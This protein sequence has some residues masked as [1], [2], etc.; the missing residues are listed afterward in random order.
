MPGLDDPAGML[1]LLLQTYRLVRAVVLLVRQPNGRALALLVVVQLVGGTVFYTLNEGW[2]WLDSLYSCV[3]TL[4]TVGLGDLAPATAAGR[5]FTI[6]FIF[7]GVGLLATFISM[8][9]QQLRS[10][11]EGD[12]R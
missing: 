5:L 7:T 6:G 1:G 2:P 8:L 10:T 11:P 3:T 9:A 12:R 4:A